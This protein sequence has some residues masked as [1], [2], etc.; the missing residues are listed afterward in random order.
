VK[1]NAERRGETSKTEQG[2][3]LVG[4]SRAAWFKNPV[5]NRIGAPQRDDPV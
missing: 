3:G 5:G 4:A 1:L 2:F